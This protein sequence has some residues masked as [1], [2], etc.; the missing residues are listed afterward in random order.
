MTDIQYIFPLLLHEVYSQILSVFNYNYNLCDQFSQKAANTG[1]KRFVF[2][3]SDSF[4]P[5][6]LQLCHV[7]SQG[8]GMENLLVHSDLLL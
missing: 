8:S 1:A 7:A 2:F 6:G 5:K 4:F 3:F